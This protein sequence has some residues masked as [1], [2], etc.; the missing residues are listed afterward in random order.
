MNYS[1]RGI[2]NSVADKKARNSQQIPGVKDGLEHG[3]IEETVPHPFGDD[4]V[5]LLDS[6][7]KTDFF[8]FAFD[9]LDRIFK[10]IG[11][12]GKVS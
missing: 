6:V 4:D 11:L 12:F 8:H 1:L 2:F 9:Q 3:L 10:V 5:D 7:R